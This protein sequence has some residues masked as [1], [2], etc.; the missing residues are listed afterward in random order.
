M[1]DVVFDVPDILLVTT[2]PYDYHFCSQGETTVAGINDGEELNLTDVRATPIPSNAHTHTHT[3]TR[4][5]P[6]II[7]FINLC[8][9]VCMG[10]H[11]VVCVCAACHGY[12][13]FHGGGEERL[14]QDSRS[15]H[16]LWEHEV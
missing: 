3:H 8:V 11:V 13:R 4:I 14:L 10:V 2:N 15:H 1:C 16:A 5:P 7:I 6:Q 12:S 9:C